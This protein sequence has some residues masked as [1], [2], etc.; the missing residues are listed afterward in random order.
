MNQP[1]RWLQT[2]SGA[3]LELPP[4]EH[5]GYGTPIAPTPYIELDL[6][7][8]DLC[9]GATCLLHGQPHEHSWTAR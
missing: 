1:S 9:P 8:L 7:D 5:G 6:T 2:R 3:W 4:P